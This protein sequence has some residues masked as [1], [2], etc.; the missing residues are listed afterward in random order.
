MKSSLQECEHDK[1]MQCAKEK[2]VKKS[3]RIEL[4]MAQQRDS[5]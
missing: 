2:A 1:C 5:F 4:V 3:I